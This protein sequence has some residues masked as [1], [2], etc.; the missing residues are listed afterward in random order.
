MAYANEYIEFL[1]EFHGSR[2]YFECH[3]I[4]EDYWKSQLP[5]DRKSVWVGL[6]QMAVGF[7]HYRRDN[8]T[9]ARRI[10]EKSYRLLKNKTKELEKLGLYSESVLTLLEETLSHITQNIAY[11]SP[12]LPIKDP[13]L[14]QLCKQSCIEKNL[15]W[16]SESD[17]SNSALIDKHLKR[18][19]Q[20]IILE[21]LQQL[22][23]RKNK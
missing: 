3:E 16:N 20:D 23:L 14:L 21:R 19:R 17:L 15:V 22:N 6:I 10:L 4:L 18:D 13:A 2:D 8:L 12:T 9:G 1:I 7:Y 5:I 11:S